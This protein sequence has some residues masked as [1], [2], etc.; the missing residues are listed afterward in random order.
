[1]ADRRSGSTVVWPVDPGA[2]GNGSSAVRPTRDRPTPAHTAPARSGRGGSVRTGQRRDPAPPASNGNGNGNG[3]GTANGNGTGNGNGNGHSGSGLVFDDAAAGPPPAR[4][5]ESARA[6]ALAL[7]RAMPRTGRSHRRSRALSNSGLRSGPPLGGRRRRVGS[8]LVPLVGAVVVLGIVVGLAVAL[9]PT[10]ARHN[11]G[12][13]SP[14][15]HSPK[16]VT[17]VTHSPTTVPP[18]PELQ[19]SSGSSST[20]AVYA[21]PAT[22]YTVDLRATTGLCWVEATQ[23]S[24]GD[25]VWTGTLQPGQTRA[26]PTTGSLFLRLGAADDVSVSVNGEQV[27]MPAG[28]QSPFDMNFSAT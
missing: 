23:E 19:P 27:L 25:V 2:G 10:P 20:S 7:S 16:K 1:M 26:I 9:A 14:G 6:T 17:H 4:S 11:D 13:K 24:T 22:A 21:A 5:D 8:R 15:P 3:N 28:F 18:P 12:L